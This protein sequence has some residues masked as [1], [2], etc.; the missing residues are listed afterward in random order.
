MKLE[1]KKAQEADK[2]EFEIL[3]Y[4]KELIRINF[5]GSLCEIG[6]VLV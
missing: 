4:R 1:P 6:N 5:N 3:D 2:K